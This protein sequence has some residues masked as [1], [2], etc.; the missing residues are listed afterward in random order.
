MMHIVAALAVVPWCDKSWN[1]RERV[2]FLTRCPTVSHM[3]GLQ[4]T[5]QLTTQ[6]LDAT[7]ALIGK[8]RSPAANSA[9]KRADATVKLPNRV[10]PMTIEMYKAAEFLALCQRSD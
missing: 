10:I 2:Q 5:F 1:S 8:S 6:G 7:S 9:A 4:Q 3:R